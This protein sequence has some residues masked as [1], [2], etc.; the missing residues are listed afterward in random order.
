MRLFC[1]LIFCLCF[2]LSWAQ[3]ETFDIITYTPPVG[4]KKETGTSVV[5][6]VATDNATGSWCRISIYKSRGSSGDARNDF[7]SEWNE[8]ITNSYADAVR[9]EPEYELEDGWTSYSGTSSFQFN[10]QDAYIMLST[11][12]GYNVEVSILVSMDSD[13]YYSEVE[14]V[15]T[16]FT[17]QKPSGQQAVKKS[18]AQTPA[19]EVKGGQGNNGISKY[20]TNFDDGWVAQPFADYVRA[21]KNNTTVLLHY[22][23][24]MTDELRA[25]NNTEGMLF[26]RLIL[27]RYQVSNLRKYEQGTCY[28]CIYFYEAD[29]VEKAT[30]KR[31][32]LGFRYIPVGGVAK[33]IE[34]ISPNAEEFNRLFPNQGAIEAIQNCNKFAVTEADLRGTW[35]EN[36]GAYANL[37]SV[38]TGLY[39]GMGS[40]SS[41]YEITFNSNGT[42]QDAFSGASGMVGNMQ[43]VGQ[44]FNG[45]YIVTNWDITL[46]NQ[47]EGKNEVYWAQFEAVRNGKILHI[48][49]KSYTDLKYHLVK[50][51]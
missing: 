24:E 17:L 16:T 37:Y 44:K 6:Y 27:P 11:I 45:N 15:L 2:G 9:P 38:S 47:L 30:G 4:W 8:L 35:E 3:Q 26:D 46:T 21:T 51:H 31:Y 41:T 36:S 7:N 14:K 28:I 49:R 5:S 25:S 33:C 23:I 18:N 50:T 34:I 32:H 19:M 20:I 48:T 10:N 22:G 43:F 39:A 13:E 42:Y 1:T 29:V 12:S 40:A